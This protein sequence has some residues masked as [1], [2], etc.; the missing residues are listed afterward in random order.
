MKLNAN[1]L[2]RVLI[3]MAFSYTAV[4]ADM[5][6]NMITAI[7]SDA[8]SQSIGGPNESYSAGA[9][10]IF[11]NPA[12]LGSH[13]QNE[14]Q[15]SNLMNSG[16]V[17]YMN[18]AVS[19]PLS[20]TQ[21]MGF[22]VFS[23]NIPQLKYKNVGELVTGKY[24]EALFNY[25]A[26][27]AHRI[28][29]ATIGLALKYYRVGISNADLRQTGEAFEMD[30]G[31][32]FAINR[33]TDFGFVYKRIVIK[34]ESGIIPD[35]NGYYVNFGMALKPIV[36]AR[37]II[38][39]LAGSGLQDG[40]LQKINYGFVLTP[41]ENGEGITSVSFRAG[42]GNDGFVYQKLQQNEVHFYPKQRSLKFGMGIVINPAE[43]WKVNLDY[44]FQYNNLY[45]NRHIITTRFLF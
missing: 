10:D 3:V 12:L 7:A 20:S 9:A 41:Y 11:I 27:Y 1:I 40:K 43:K 39:F 34:K 30:V 44:C 32:Q 35:G 36:A 42:V 45:E 13:Q 23:L 28:S 22:G 6:R 17:K 26:A 15:L 16:M 37:N 8:F 4:W 24:D 5:S 31:G 18:A 21:F 29:G 14:I 38:H 2:Q 25:T 33:T 19:I